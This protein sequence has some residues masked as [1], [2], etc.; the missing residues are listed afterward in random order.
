MSPG[1]GISD[2]VS[3]LAIVAVLVS[4]WMHSSLCMAPGLARMPH[5][6]TPHETAEG[7]G[8][9]RVRRAPEAAQASRGAEGKEHDHVTRGHRV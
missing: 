2:D 1:M 3:M 4:L 6:R 7:R 9:G 5:G 8:R